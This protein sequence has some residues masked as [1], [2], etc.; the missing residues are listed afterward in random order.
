MGENFKVEHVIG[1]VFQKDEHNLTKDE[2]K[3]GVKLAVPAKELKSEEKTKAIEWYGAI[4]CD[5]IGL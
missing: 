4:P 5:F 2:N 1:D 3:F